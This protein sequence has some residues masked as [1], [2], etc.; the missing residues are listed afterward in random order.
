MR[1]NYVY[2]IILVDI[3]T[4]FNDGK[5]NTPSLREHAVGLLFFSRE[6]EQS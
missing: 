4:T 5:L 1:P 2:V 3:Q 6:R